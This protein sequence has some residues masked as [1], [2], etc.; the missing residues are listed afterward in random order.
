VILTG[1]QNREEDDDR[2]L[3]GDPRADRLARNPDARW[4]VIDDLVGG[5]CELAISPWPTLTDEGRLRFSD[6]E[7]EHVVGVIDAGYFYDVVRRARSA[8]LTGG[9]RSPTPESERPLRVGDTFIAVAVP[10]D[11]GM[12]DV[13]RGPDDLVDITAH[14]RV[15]AKVQVAVADR[16]PVDAEQLPDL[17]GDEEAPA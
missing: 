9:P 2:L 1:P 12:V 17:R 3:I 7:D 16:S 4:V 15:F 5:R 6:D 11:D 14:A 8:Q 10:A 13:L